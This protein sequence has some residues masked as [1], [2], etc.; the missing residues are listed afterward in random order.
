MSIV[1]LLKTVDILNGLSDSQLE[2]VA[3]LCREQTRNADDIIFK[4]NDRMYRGIQ[5]PREFWK[6]IGLVGESGHQ[7]SATAYLLSQANMIR[8]LEE[9]VF[10]PFRIFQ[11]GIAT[12]ESKTCLDFGTIRDYDP[13]LAEVF[14]RAGSLICRRLLFRR[15]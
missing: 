3:Q 11:V 2:K 13:F 10:G 4:E 6:I 9:F 7:M 1:Q 12:L 8:D 14:E 5:I 15:W